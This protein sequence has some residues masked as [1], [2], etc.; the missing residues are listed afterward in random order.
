MRLVFSHV[1]YHVELCLSKVCFTTCN[2]ISGGRGGGGKKK[3]QFPALAAE[4]E[5]QGGWLGIEF[6]TIS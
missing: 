4:S 2:R 1:Q 3:T 6:V 5:P